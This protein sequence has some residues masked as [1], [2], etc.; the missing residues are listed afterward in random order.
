MGVKGGKV[1]HKMTTS[2]FKVICPKLL[3]IPNSSLLK[4]YIFLVHLLGSGDLS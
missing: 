1:K 3:A 2:H 4:K